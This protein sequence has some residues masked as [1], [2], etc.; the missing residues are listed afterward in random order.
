MQFDSLA[1]NTNQKDATMLQLPA[2]REA[3]LGDGAVRYER[4][5]PERTPSFF[6][7]FAEEYYPVFETQWAAQGRVLPNYVRR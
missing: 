5:S 3:S 2:G 4:H 6:Y 1:I 7:Q